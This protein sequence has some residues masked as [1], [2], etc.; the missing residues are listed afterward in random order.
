[1]LLERL[2]YNSRVITST[3]KTTN[4]SNRIWLL[5]NNHVRSEGS[6]IWGWCSKFTDETDY[7]LGKLKSA[8]A[9]NDNLRFLDNLSYYQNIK[10]RMKIP[11]AS[12]NLDYEKVLW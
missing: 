11:N 1:M 3:A 9:I 12:Y 7:S 10:E 2:C 8:F 4:V 5:S 6:T